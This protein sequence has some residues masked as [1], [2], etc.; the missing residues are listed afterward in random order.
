MVTNGDP[1]LR[2]VAWQDVRVSDDRLHDGYAR[3]GLDRADSDIPKLLIL[4]DFIKFYGRAMNLTSSLEDESLD[5]HVIEG[6]QV[7]ALARSLSLSGRW[8]DVGSG[9]GFPG[10]VLAA[11]LDIDLTLV[12]PRAKRASVLELGLGKLRRR[13]ARVLRGRIE[14]GRWLGLEGARLESGFQVASAR[15]VWGPEQWLGEAEPWVEPGGLVVLH[16]GL[17]DAV[18]IHAGSGVAGRVDGARWAVVGVRMGATPG[19]ES[20]SSD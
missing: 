3:L 4:K 10:L 11:C 20:G 2:P 7:V 9:G 6:L 15:A 14:R 16:V 5:Q 17:G 1:N 13:N 18:P 12:E 8:L 19:S